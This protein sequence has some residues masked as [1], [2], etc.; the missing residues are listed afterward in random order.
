MKNTLVLLWLLTQLAF[1]G[2]AFIWIL[3]FLGF[4]DETKRSRST[5]LLGKLLVTLC[6]AIGA[7]P[8][9]ITL[10]VA[11]GYFFS[12]DFFK[13]LPLGLLLPLV[14]TLV[15]RLVC[16]GLIYLSN[17]NGYRRDS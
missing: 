9:G 10:V 11:W 13:E 5:A 17:L 1:A 14:S 16:A 15:S 8:I 2:F 3:A 4:T 12:A 7:I 6:G